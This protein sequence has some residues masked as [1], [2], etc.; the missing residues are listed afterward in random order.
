MNAERRRQRLQSSEM[1]VEEESGANHPRRSQMR[2]VRQNELQWR[3][4]VRRGA[5][6]DLTLAE[7]FGDQPEFEVFEVAQ[8]AM[9]EL[10]ASRRSMRGEVVLLDQQH[11][12]S[13]S[14]GV[15]RD[16]GPVDPAAG[17]DE[18]VVGNIR[19]RHAGRWRTAAP[20]LPQP[21][22]AFCA[23]ITSHAQPRLQST[24]AA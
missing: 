6:E 17:D 13:A 20:I 19:S 4:D 12:E 18:I 10:G 8:S 2:L 11:L 3:N 21:V 15:A 16:T 9:D 5:Q 24:A 7:R 22:A 23:T 1:A 14:G